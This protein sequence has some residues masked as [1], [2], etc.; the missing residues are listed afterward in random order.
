MEY[1]FI[2]NFCIWERITDFVKKI[3]IG[4]GQNVLKLFLF[5][6]VIRI[7]TYMYIYIYYC[8]K[9]ITALFVIFMAGIKIGDF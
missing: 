1:Q 4:C 7:N 8:H 5:I 3:L 6:I 9:Y 2:L